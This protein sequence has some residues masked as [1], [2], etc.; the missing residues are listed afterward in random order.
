MTYNFSQTNMYD[1]LPSLGLHQIILSIRKI[2]ACATLHNFI[3]AEDGVQEMEEA[4]DPACA[5]ENQTTTPL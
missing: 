1:W 2:A 4:E 3:I 5:G